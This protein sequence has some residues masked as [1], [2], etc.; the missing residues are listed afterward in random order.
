MPARKR[1]TPDEFEFIRPHLERQKEQNIE[2]VR[3]VLVDGVKQ[4]DLAAELG[5]TVQGVS[6]MVAR[7]WN[8]HVE[9]GERPIGWRVVHVA[10]PDHV[11]DVIEEM[12]DI[13]RRRI[14]K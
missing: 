7:A 2:H 9:H 8:I 12:A 11:A 13:A 3:R 6:A 4:R 5:M 10:L 1:L 14:R